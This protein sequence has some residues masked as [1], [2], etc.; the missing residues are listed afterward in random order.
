MWCGGYA[1]ITIILFRNPTGFEWSGNY[2]C[3]SILMCPR[4]ENLPWRRSNTDA[5]DRCTLS[6]RK[7][8]RVLYAPES[9]SYQFRWSDLSFVSLGGRVWSES[10]WSHS[11]PKRIRIEIR[12]TN[13]KKGKQDASAVLCTVTEETCLSMGTGSA[14]ELAHAQKTR[15]TRQPARDPGSGGEN[16]GRREAAARLHFEIRSPGREPGWA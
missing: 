13:N 4:Q 11:K 15:P 1:S 9:L 16:G 6:T 5:I 8:K 7:R 14:R 3:R 10:N 2:P 12:P